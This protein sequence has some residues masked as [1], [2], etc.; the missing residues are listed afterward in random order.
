M[1]SRHNGGRNRRKYFSLFDSGKS[2]QQSSG[3]PGKSKVSHRMFCS[4]SPWV[5]LHLL[6]FEGPKFFFLITSYAWSSPDHKTK[7]GFKWI[8][9]VQDGECLNLQAVVL[10]CW[11]LTGDTPPPLSKLVS[12][13]PGISGLQSRWNKWVQG[14]LCKGSILGISLFWT[15]E[16]SLHAC[17]H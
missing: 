15:W 6:C 11:G 14:N 12:V 16:L 17:P 2:D 4:S 8:V 1:K 10:D 9:G 5:S 13:H 7:T 3:K